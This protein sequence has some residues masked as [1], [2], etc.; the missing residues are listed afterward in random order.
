MKSWKK[1]WKSELDAVIPDLREDVKRQPIV[2]GAPHPK[3][4]NKKLLWGGLGGLGGL[5]AVVCVVLLCVLLPPKPAAASPQAYVFLYEINPAVTVSTD[6]HG[7][8]TGVAAANADADIVLGNDRSAQMVGKSVA[9]ALTWYTDRAVQLGYLDPFARSA[10]R[11][12]ACEQGVET[13]A[14]AKNALV[15]YFT[16][17]GIYAAVADVSL[18]LDAFTER[19][20]MTAASVT[21]L[22]EQTTG[23]TTSYRDRRVEG[24]TPDELQ[25]IYREGVMTDGL[26][27]A[28]HDLLNDNFTRIEQNAADIER[29][30]ALYDTI[31]NHPDNPSVLGG[32]YWVVKMFYG[33]ALTGEFAVLMGQMADALTQYENDYGVKI[34]SAFDLKRA[35]DSYLAVS[36]SDL[37]KILQNFTDG[38]LYVYGSVLSQIMDA[39]GIG[40]QTLNALL[41]VP[42]TVEAY[43]SKA[44]EAV[45]VETEYRLDKYADV[46]NAERDAVAADEYQ[47]FVASV[48]SEYGSLDAF[49]AA[50]K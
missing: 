7:T 18:P 28:T 12:S 30:V 17:H 27:Q 19:C 21:A 47:R 8:V 6:S 43:L 45:A 40:S 36:L 32:D 14:A 35:A 39:V 5:A 49:Y 41:Q 16:E 22:V 37:R 13:L 33:D 48:T 4:P 15:E 20:G 11:L 31:Y 50:Q 38:V 23:G 9:E 42:D 44:N 25:T 24:A 46:Y 26:A 34:D 3:R 1:R 29:L 10:V 2:T